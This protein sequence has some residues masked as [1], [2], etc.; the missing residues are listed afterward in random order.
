MVGHLALCRERPPIR[1]SSK[2]GGRGYLRGPPSKHH[3]QSGFR[4]LACGESEIPSPL[5]PSC[6]QVRVIAPISLIRIASVSKRN[7]CMANLACRSMSIPRA[8]LER[9]RTSA[10]YA[11]L[12]WAALG[13]RAKPRMPPCLRRLLKRNKQSAASR[14][15]QGAPKTFLRTLE[16]PPPSSDQVH[17]RG[18]HIALTGPPRGNSKGLPRRLLDCADHLHM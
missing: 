14:S 10:R 16:T 8:I 2:R 18:R 7:C 4:P 13:F 5:Q 9:A 17:R 1:G 6:L 12:H 15:P 11:G 3:N